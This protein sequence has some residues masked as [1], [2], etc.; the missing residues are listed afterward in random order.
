MAG[1]P[2]LVVER[3]EPEEAQ[4]PCA[5]EVNACVREMGQGFSNSRS[6]MEGC[7]VKHFAQLSSECQCFVHHITNGRVPVPPASAARVVTSAPEP[8]AVLIRTVSVPPTKGPGAVEVTMDGTMVDMPSHPRALHQVSC[9]F[10]FLSLVLVT[11]FL[12]RAIFS[13]LCRGARSRPVVVV[14][15]EQAM[16]KCVGTTPPLLVSEIT[17]PV[18][19]A[20]PFSKA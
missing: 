9:L 8:A 6:A 18:Q 15:P 12:V 2:E 13:L 4:H 3:D 14:P 11:F 10:V 20:E 1:P 7:L 17:K 19:V 5:R 16:I